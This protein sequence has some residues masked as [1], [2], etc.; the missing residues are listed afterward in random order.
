M[1]SNISANITT[2]ARFVLKL[3]INS[4]DTNYW[5]KYTHIQNVL[6]S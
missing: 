6:E 3:Y 1:D 2:A 5:N 4:C